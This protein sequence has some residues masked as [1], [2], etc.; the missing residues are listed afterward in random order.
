MS[1]SFFRCIVSER[2]DEEALRA[3]SS[4]FSHSIV[5]FVCRDLSNN[6]LTGSIPDSIGNLKSGLYVFYYFQGRTPF[7]ISFVVCVFLKSL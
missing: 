7:D 6:Q 4:V 5:S 2:V 3:R 1:D